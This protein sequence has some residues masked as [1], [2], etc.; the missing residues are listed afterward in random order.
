MTDMPDTTLTSDPSH[1][2]DAQE[3]DD[4]AGYYTPG[5]PIQDTKAPGGPLEERWDTRQFEARIA[6]PNFGKAPAAVQDGA[7]SMLEQKRRELAALKQQEER[8]RAL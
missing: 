8:V 4:A 7:R 3:T 6:N 5:D 2:R 1:H